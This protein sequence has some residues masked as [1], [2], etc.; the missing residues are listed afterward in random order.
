[1]EAGARLD[2]ALGTIPDL[3]LAEVVDELEALL[4]GGAFPVASGVRWTYGATVVAAHEL[5]GLALASVGDDR[6][7]LGADAVVL[8]TVDL[9]GFLAL[10]DHVSVTLLRVFRTLDAVVVVI[11]NLICARAV[12]GRQFEALMAF[13]DFAARANT[14]LRT[15][16]THFVGR[17]YKVAVRTSANPVLHHVVLAT[18]DKVSA[19]ADPVLRTGSTFIILY[20][21]IIAADTLVDHSRKC[22]EAVQRSILASGICGAVQ[23]CG[24]II[25]NKFVTRTQTFLVR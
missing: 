3:G 18:R 13:N 8:V 11:D 6:E 20:E 16:L 23:T 14:I 17:L 4:A 5:G 21:L 22:F 10:E 24:G 19:I 7:A 9:E 2:V 12:I 1:M 15:F 25:V